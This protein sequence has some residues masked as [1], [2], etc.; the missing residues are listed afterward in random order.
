MDIMKFS[1]CCVLVTVLC[2]V[3][4]SGGERVAVPLGHN[5][6]LQCTPV[7][8][9]EQFATYMWTLNSVLLASMGKDRLVNIVAGSYVGKMSMLP[10]DGSLTVLDLRMEDSGNYTCGLVVMVTNETS[11]DV[12]FPNMEKTYEVVVQDV[13]SSPNEPVLRDIQSSQVTVTWKASPNDNNSPVKAYILSV[14]E[15]T[16]SLGATPVI[17]QELRTPS[18]V[19]AKTVQ[20]LQPFTCYTVNV[21]A[22]N[23]MGLS[24]PSRPSQE[25]YTE[26]EDYMADA[27]STFFI[28]TTDA[29]NV[30]IKPPG[31]APYNFVASG[32]SSSAILLEWERPPDDLLNGQLMGY[33]INYGTEVL[34]T[35]NIE[36]PNKVNTTLEGLHP[37]TMYRVFIKAYNSAGPGPEEA[38][39]VQTKEGVPSKPRITHISNRQSNSFYVNWEPPVRLNGQLIRY[40]LTWMHNNTTMPRSITGHLIKH[41]T[42]FVQ[43]L[44]PYTL[45]HVKVAAVTNGG[46]G[47]FSDPFPALTDVAA[48]GP[49]RNLNITMKGPRSVLMTWE[50]PKV[51]YKNVDNYL[52][53]GWDN[54]GQDVKVEVMGHLTEYN[55]TGLRMNT[56]YHLKVAAVTNALFSSNKWVGDFT[57][58][59]KFDIGENVIDGGNVIWDRDY[60]NSHKD[61]DPN[62]VTGTE[63]DS[64]GIGAGIIAG[65]VCAV[66]LLLVVVA[67]VVGYRWYTCR[68]CYQAAYL[69]LAVP[70]NGQSVQPAI[71]HVEEPSEGKQYPD[72]PV[73][74]F[75][76]HVNQMHTDSD[77]AFAQEFDEIN[78]AS[79]S[80]KYPCDHSNHSENR[81]KNRYVNIVAYDH[82][83]VVLLKAEMG[84]LRQSDYINANYVDG[85]KKPK[86]YI[87]TQGPLP[88]TF[89]DFWRMVWEQNTSVIVMITNLM[90]KERRKC[91]QY[92]PSDGVETYGSMQVKL[93]TTVP[94]AHYTVRVFSLRNM[95]VKKRHSMKASAERTVYHYHYT[96][97]P[98]HG[99]PDYSLPVLSFVQKSA[100]Q[101]GPEHGPIIVHC[102]AG[103]GRTGTYILIDSMMAQIQDKKSINIPGFTQHIRRQRNFLVQTEDQYI[104]I[105][106]V[107]VEYLLGGGSTEVRDEAL[108][109]H[110]DQ[111][112]RP[113]KSLLLPSLT[114]SS[115]LERQYQLVT[116][117]TPSEQDMAAAL[118][119]FNQEKNRLG[120]ILPV[121]LKRVLLP[122]RPGVEGSNYINATYLQ[123]YRKSAEFLVTQHPTVDTMEDFW[124]MV[125]DKNSPVI[126]VLSEFDDIEYKEFWP[127]KGSSIEVDAGNFRLTMKEEPVANEGQ[128]FVTYE[129]ILDSIQYDYTL[130]TRIICVSGWPSMWEGH[131]VFSPICHAFDF[132][133]SLECG[134]IVVMDR[135]GGVEA[136]QFCALWTLRDQVLSEKCADFYQVAKL[137][138]YKRPGIIGKQEDYQFL[139]RA[140]AAFYKHCREEH[141]ANGSSSPRHHHIDIF[142]HNSARKNGTLPRSNANNN[143]AP[144]PVSN[145]TPSNITDAAVPRA[146]TRIGRSSSGDSVANSNG[147]NNPSTPTNEEAKK[148]ETNI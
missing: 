25:F 90:E 16:S 70:S 9:E 89:P 126:V 133:N 3:A 20:G 95:K 130:M 118:K 15:C 27:D 33:E 12:S 113:S 98:D 61:Y 31:V 50:V 19:L 107:L 93:I 66:V 144:A 131:S 5:V 94:R 119:P 114:T 17:V 68:R 47:E 22:E 125:W 142:H 55:L 136:G 82:S 97:W 46:L 75:L 28:N 102:S 39:M 24:L 49:P 36:D 43:G 87:A 117:Y 138:H 57:K 64:G 53:K 84:R 29:V 78:R 74:D 105:H 51:F 127:P 148:T 11:G 121:N 104:F 71:I 2:C 132:L 141:A 63:P 10:V 6:T 79:C 83:R 81:N 112:Q 67:L 116:E 91:D 48:P 101:S 21:A 137:Y 122:A 45:Y 32:I 60:G 120:S 41:M 7:G 26:Q 65:I 143:A 4:L 38:Q 72:I 18:S 76:G 111:L 58:V 62:A 54:R 13:P 59:Q 77:I 110:M 69:Y 134:P 128:G 135:F 108:M 42:A 1:G 146:G 147:N 14:K 85:Y 44:K 73:E 123:G 100:A 40:E 35:I 86:A 115:L 145:S 52:I 92:W 56:R 124:R 139:H 8:P 96:E 23:A 129:F 140:M 30:T 103:V 99:V 37:F 80:D 106:S 88:Q 34:K 109:D